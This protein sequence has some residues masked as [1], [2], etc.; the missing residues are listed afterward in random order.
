MLAEPQL[1]PD[2]ALPKNDWLQFAR[3]FLFDQMIR[4]TGNP[5]A[6]KRLKII[7]GDYPSLLVVDNLV[8]TLYDFERT[9]PDGRPARE[10]FIPAAAKVVG[11]LPLEFAHATHRQQVF[12]RGVRNSLSRRK[13]NECRME[14]LRYMP[15]HPQLRTLL[16]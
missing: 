11:K 5:E 6:I 1:F 12:A 14:K 7:R 13:R 9:L 10:A 16:A 2:P 8:L 4:Q 3:A 15:R